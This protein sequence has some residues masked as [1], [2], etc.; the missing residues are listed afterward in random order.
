[1]TVDTNIG[2]TTDLFGKYVA[3]LQENV[4]IG[5]NSISGHLLYQD[6]YTGFSS[7][8][9]EQTGNYL[10]IHCNIPGHTAD[11]YSISVKVTNPVTLDSDGIVVLR[12]AD[13]DSQ[14]ITVVASASGL[15]PYTKVFRLSDLVCDS[16]V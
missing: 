10:A 12:I 6:D 3:D 1:M 15:D 5:S 11:E 8:P 14:T 4:V 16:E 7:K 13:K 2:A 9:E